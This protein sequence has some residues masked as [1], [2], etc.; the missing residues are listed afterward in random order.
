MRDDHEGERFLV[1]IDSVEGDLML[2]C[3][4]CGTEWRPGDPIL[5]RV[6]GEAVLDEGWAP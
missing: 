3:D 1:A 4:C 5:C 2:R 6:C